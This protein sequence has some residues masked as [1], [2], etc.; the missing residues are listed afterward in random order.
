[1]AQLTRRTRS[2]LREPEP[3][4]VWEWAEKNRSLPKSVT[5]RPG[6]YKTAQAPFQREPQE[7]FTDD[8]V[9]VTVL[10]WASRLGKTEIENNLYGYIID[11]DPCHVLVV[12]PTLDSGKKWSKEMFA[13]MLAAS[14]VLASKVA[15]PRSRDSGNTILAKRFPGGQIA[16]IGSN[17]PSGFRQI[18][19]PV[20]VC[21]EIDAMEAGTEGDPIDLAMRRS[22][23]YAR[24]IQVLSSTPTIKHFSRIESWMER[25]DYRKWYVPCRQ[26]GH[27]FVL[28][29][30]HMDFSKRGGI[31]SPYIICPEC[32]KDHDDEQRIAMVNAGE[33]RP[34]Q[35]FHGIRGYWLNGMNTTFPAKKGF[36]GNKLYQMAWEFL[37][38]KKKGPDNLQTWTNTFAA[39]TYEEEGHKIEAHSILARRES[40]TPDLLPESGLLITC[41]ADVH[42]D[43]I[44]CESVIWAEEEESWGIE[45]VTFYG[46]IEHSEIWAELD[47]HFAKSYYHPRYGNLQPMQCFVD[48]GHRQDLVLPWTLRRSGRG[49]H[50]C[51]GLSTRGVKQPPVC[52]ERPS[53]K[54]DYKAPQYMVGVNEAKRVIYDRIQVPP[55]GPRTCHFPKGNGYDTTWAEQLVVEVRRTKHSYGIPYSI[56]ENPEGKPNH[57]LDC[58]VYAYAAMVK[59]NLDWSGIRQTLEVRAAGNSKKSVDKPDTREDAGGEMNTGGGNWATNW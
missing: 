30:E 40:Y 23:N 51:K 49:I 41:G 20:V 33:W 12:Y 38:A 18:Q 26:C 34:T 37:E 29:W 5:P 4:L 55:P 19:A 10:Q 31:E 24:S 9:M 15:D 8:T 36:S 59:M 44:E 14:S 52:E 21:D 45:Y 3:L 27:A 47:R 17:S 46:D 50:A 2:L 35:A 58:R 11:H 1:M 6:R 16:A 48:S 28:M 32:G 25:S 54:N 56:F 7:S 42:D 57:S 13:P 39:E 53:T 43:R 22:D